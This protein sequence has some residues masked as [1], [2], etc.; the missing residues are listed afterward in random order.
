MV[1]NLTGLIMRYCHI[2][3]AVVASGTARKPTP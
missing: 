1:V 3:A 2:V